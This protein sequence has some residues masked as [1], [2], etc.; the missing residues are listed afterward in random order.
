M[1]FSKENISARLSRLSLLPALLATIFGILLSG[2]V[3]LPLWVLIAGFLLSTLSAWVTLRTSW[4]RLYLCVAIALLA[5]ISV[6]LHRSTPPHVNRLLCDIEV[7][8][9]TSQSRRTSGYGRIVATYRDTVALA[10][11]LPVRISADSTLH[12]T[13]GTRLRAVCHLRPF[14]V[15]DT[16]S[17]NRYMARRGYVGGVW[18]GERDIFHCDTLSGIGFS[19]GKVALDNLSRLALSPEAMATAAA[20]TLGRR[21]MLSAQTKE[22]YRRSGGAHLLAVSGLHVGYIYVIVGALLGFLLLVRNGQLWRSVLIVAIMWIYVAVV[23]FAPSVVRAAVMFSIVQIIVALSSSPLS[24]NTLFGSAMIIL[25]FSPQMLW[26]AGFVLSCLAVASIVAWGVPL[27]LSLQRHISTLFD[28]HYRL[29]PSVATYLIMWVVS[30]VV[31]SIV[32]S[33]A[34][35]PLVACMFG[36]TSLWGI[37]SGPLVVALC[38]VVVGAT[39]LWIIFP[40]GFLSPLFGWIIEYAASA[41]NSVSAWCAEREVLIFEG[42]ISLSACV[43]IYL[44]YIVAT[45]VIWSREIKKL[46]NL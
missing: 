17:F 22:D 13:S 25:W 24:L 8:G 4:G 33:L 31:V 28:A 30:A 40:I 26:D 34:T 19:V 11:N 3:I 10:C 44:F 16:A 23:G 32:A 9:I 5:A 2:C 45:V 43:V 42:R 7:E 6:E 39:L 21:E 18:L 12:L 1:P 35:M 46:P 15:T 29:W 27:I 37:V 20:V 38:G 14:A 36:L 41:M